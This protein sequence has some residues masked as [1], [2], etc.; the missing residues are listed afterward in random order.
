MEKGAWSFSDFWDENSCTVFG[1]TRPWTSS[2]LAEPC[3]SLKVAELSPL[4]GS[5]L[6][7][8]VR[9][10]TNRWVY[11]KGTVGGCS[12]ASKHAC[13]KDKALYRDPSRTVGVKQRERR[14]WPTGLSH[15][16]MSNHLL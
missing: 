3:P 7:G 11:L 14:S 10:R 12:D 13:F 8:L 9:V 1:N 2:A 6:R 4:G 16:D 5:L 15:H